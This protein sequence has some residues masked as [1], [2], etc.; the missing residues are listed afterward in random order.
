M[1]DISSL[2]V[3]RLSWWKDLQTFGGMDQTNGGYG[4]NPPPYNTDDYGNSPYT[5]MSYQVSGNI[6]TFLLASPEKKEWGSQL[7]PCFF[8]FF[9]I[10]FGFY[11][12]LL[13]QHTAVFDLGIII[14]P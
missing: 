5:G 10:H 2:S 1:S 7:K 14:K 11:I 3:L 8:F 9:H 6:K 12:K 4:A 13:V